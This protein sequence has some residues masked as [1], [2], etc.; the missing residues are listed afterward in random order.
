[1]QL[2]AEDILNSLVVAKITLL[3]VMRSPSRQGILKMHK[4]AEY[5]AMVKKIINMFTYIDNG[6]ILF[7]SRQELINRCR[8]IYKVILKWGLTMHIGYDRKK[9][10]TKVMF[11]PSTRKLKE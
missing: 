9:S 4:K 5:D 6:A 2:V 10:K 11:F 1:M 8:I 7:N 3:K